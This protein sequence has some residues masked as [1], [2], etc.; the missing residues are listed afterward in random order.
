[1]PKE[2]GNGQNP[3]IE[4]GVYPSSTFTDLNDP[5]ARA[6]FK[7]LM[8]SQYG[9]SGG[10]V[11]RHIELMIQQDEWQRR[12]PT[13]LAEIIDPEHEHFGRI[14]Q[15]MFAM[16][17][18]FVGKKPLRKVFPEEL[19]SNTTIQNRLALMVKIDLLIVDLLEEQCRLIEKSWLVEE[20][21]EIIDENGR[22]GRLL[23]WQPHDQF[24]RSSPYGFYRAQFGNEAVT[25]EDHLMMQEPTWQ[26][27]KRV[28][29]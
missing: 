19:N 15:P 24:P 23:D 27:R 10:E 5:V 9:F 28:K 4:T 7:A 21:I 29:K 20:E 3:K 22:S 26:F 18:A 8:K 25:K 13:C 1:M 12:A 14:G 6:N 2:N 16:P 11:E 17:E